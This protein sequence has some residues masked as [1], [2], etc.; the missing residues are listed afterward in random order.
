M[1]YL[2]TI[3]LFLFTCSFAQSDV[4]NEARPGS[5]EHNSKFDTFYD[6]IERA[7][8]IFTENFNGDNTVAGL[9]ARGWVWNNVDGGGT[10]ATFQGSTT[11][12]PAYEGPADGYVGQNF[13]GA[14]GL[15]IDQ[16]L[17]SPQ[18]TV[19]PGDTL[20]FW[21]RST[22]GQW[23][24]SVYV[25]ISDGGSNI[26]DFTL[27]LGRNQLPGEWTN[28]KY[29]FTGS[30]TKRV[31]FRYYLTSGGPNGN[32]SDYWGLDFLTVVSGI[33][34][35]V[36][37]P[38]YT[39]PANGATNVALTG[40]TALWTNGANTEAVEVWFGPAGNLAQV[41]N[42]V[43]ISS[44]NIPQ[45]N[46]NTQYGWQVINKNDS[47]QAAGPVWTFTTM[48]DPDIV[49]LFM[50]DFETGPGNWTITNEGG[51]CV[52]EIRSAPFPNV[53]TMPASS[54]GA[55]FTADSD[56]CGSG[57]TMLTTATLST[58]INAGIYQAIELS[59]DNDWRHLGATS[60]AHVEVSIDGGTTWVSVWSQVGVSVRATTEVLDISSAVAMQT[61]LL[62]FRSVQPGW[63]WWWVID[64]VKVRGFNAIPVELASFTTSVSDNNVTLSWATA[65]ETN[66]SGFEVQRKASGEEFAPVGFV[67]GNGTTTE[68][69][70]YTYTDQ[71]LTSGT[72]QYRLKQIDYDGTFEYSP[73]VEADITIPKVFG[74]EQNYPNP[75]NP[76]TSIKFSLASDA[77][78]NL[79]VYSI[80]GE[81]V[82]TLV[83]N[84]MTAGVHTISFDASN[85]TSGVYFYRID[86]NGVDGTNF[87]SVKKMI[88]TK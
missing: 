19:S 64:N 43:P 24:D 22:G 6:G 32:H 39:A 68:L 2:V 57:S 14:N 34:C 23:H 74:L 27:N 11:V 20:S 56:E 86:A 82:V 9:E 25:L 17:I 36:Q 88:L 59:F 33:E 1:K 84:A 75:F 53:Y 26:S 15:L 51:A 46:Y 79:T 71:G 81:E 72:Y 28:Y 42:G 5:P 48:E 16:W 18:F 12:F 10:S 3:F 45:L 52:W 35:P 21:W 85:L 80:L 69:Q 8:P 40:N 73:V 7:T 41:Y 76:S 77:N 58:A 78:V 38:T 44:L 13:N 65:T 30:G 55:V 29:I 60:E 62:R 37:P 70:Y 63:H 4:V 67:V 54:S 66:N 83:N 31:A 61:F 87:S 47:C 49:T 50:D